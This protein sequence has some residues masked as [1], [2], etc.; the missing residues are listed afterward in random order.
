MENAWLLLTLT[1]CT[2]AN[3]ELRQSVSAT[4]MP[5]PEEFYLEQS[6]ENEPIESGNWPVDDDDYDNSGSGSGNF[7]TKVQMVT[8]NPAQVNPD[9]KPT[10]GAPKSVTMGI[11]PTT[12]KKMGRKPTRT[13]ASKHNMV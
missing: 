10:S 7:E 9:V 5:W 4:K 6:F 3:G 2:L 8:Y 13:E 11:D 12:Q 1:F